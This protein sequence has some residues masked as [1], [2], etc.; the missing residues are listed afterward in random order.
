M[1][2]DPRLSTSTPAVCRVSFYE[3]LELANQLSERSGLAPCYMLHCE[4]PATPGCA[5]EGQPYCEDLRKCTASRNAGP[6]GY[7]LPTTGGGD[8][9]LAIWLEPETFGEVC[10]VGGRTRLSS[11]DTAPHRRAPTRC[12][13][14]ADHIGIRLLAAPAE[15]PSPSESGAQP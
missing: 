2:Y 9:E 11:P 1:G 12:G 6:C 7:R 4:G 5:R 3:A 14:R 13:L 10:L 8:G 15:A